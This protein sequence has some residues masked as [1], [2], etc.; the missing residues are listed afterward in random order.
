ME[1]IGKISALLTKITTGRENSCNLSFEVNPEN[2]SVVNRL[3]ERYLLGEVLYDIS[4]AVPCG[5]NRSV[6]DE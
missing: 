2:I 1:D 3:M 4:I 6:N 5:E